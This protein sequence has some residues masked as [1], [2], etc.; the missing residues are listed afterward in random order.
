MSIIRKI[1][2]FK[3]RTSITIDPTLLEMAKKEGLNLSALL[4]LAIIRYFYNHGLTIDTPYTKRYV[5]L[6]KKGLLKE[7]DAFRC[8]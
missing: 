4:E 1:R 5:K 8:E 2:G 7:L 3:K 6:A